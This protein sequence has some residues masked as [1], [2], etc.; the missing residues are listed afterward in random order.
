MG[1]RKKAGYS[2]PL[3]QPALATNVLRAKEHPFSIACDFA[4]NGGERMA[5][6]KDLS[7]QQH[8]FEGRL[9]Y[10]TDPPTPTIRWSLIAG[11]P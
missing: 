3:E 4:S 9:Y 5:V 8:R 10:R 1:E 11:R 6:N 7:I 2:H